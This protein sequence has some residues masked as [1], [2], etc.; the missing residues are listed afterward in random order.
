MI[1]SLIKQQDVKFTDNVHI[2]RQKW[3]LERKKQ[4]FSDSYHF[5]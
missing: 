4:P 5:M 2:M 3:N 1:A